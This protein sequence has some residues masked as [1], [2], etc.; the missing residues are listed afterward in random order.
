MELSRPDDAESGKTCHPAD[1][2]ENETEG[3][4][5]ST[6]REA[7]PRV[8]DDILALAM[9]SLFPVRSGWGR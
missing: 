8:E 7:L 2:E 4:S 6:F 9:T 3:V 5:V 1:D